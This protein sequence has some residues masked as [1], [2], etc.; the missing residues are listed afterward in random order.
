MVVKFYSRLRGWLV[1]FNSAALLSKLKISSVWLH[2]RNVSLM[3]PQD[4]CF[5][6]F[7]T[8]NS[9]LSG[10]KGIVLCLMQ[11]QSLSQC[12]IVMAG[13][14]NLSMS[15]IQGLMVCHILRVVL[16]FLIGVWLSVRE[17]CYYVVVSVLMT[18]FSSDVFASLVSCQK[19]IVIASN[20]FQILYSRIWK[21]LLQLMLR[22]LCSLIHWYLWFIIWRRVILTCTKSFLGLPPPHLAAGCLSRPS[23]CGKKMWITLF[24]FIVSIFWTK[25]SL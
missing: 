21:V 3:F 20:M 19:G 18:T 8:T 13:S 15:M 24:I 9:Y 5:M 11:R 12:P 2:T 10:C 16:A 14:Q 17:Q 6:K 23:L 25:L 7:Q 22:F 1:D 4:H